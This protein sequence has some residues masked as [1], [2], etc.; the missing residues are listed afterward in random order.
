MFRRAKNYDAGEKFLGRAPGGRRR[1]RE[2]AP[3]EADTPPEADDLVAGAPTGD[4]L[5]A[6][7]GDGPFD[8]AD[9]DRDAL[10]ASG[11]YLDLGS[12]LIR[13]PDGAELRLPVSEEDQRVLAALV[14][15]PES[16]VELTVFAAPRSGGMWEQV[17]EE[18]AENAVAAGGTAETVVEPHGREL[19]LTVPG[20]NGVSQQ[21]R[22]WG[23]DGPRWMLRA[24]VV[25]VAAAGGDALD[26]VRSLLAGV[27]VTR[28]G[29]PMAP[30][31][32][33]PLR[34]PEGL[35]PVE[36]LPDA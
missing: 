12:L 28:G 17:A 18:I 16:A 31:E 20:E 9:V 33:L 22:L 25:G 5:A 15:L 14:V 10:A 6:P 26:E 8:S 13:V 30:R 34:L 4:P 27:V 1:G 35:T 3:A 32:P 24:N 21:Q 2:P 29:E 11:S 36:E 19:R 23:F 7:E